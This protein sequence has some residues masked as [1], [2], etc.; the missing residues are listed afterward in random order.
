MGTL[1]ESQDPP[2]LLI[3]VLQKAKAN[4]PFLGL[5]PLQGSPLPQDNV[6]TPSSLWTEASRSHLSAAHFE[7]IPFKNPLPP[8][9]LSLDF[10]PLAFI[11]EKQPSF[12]Q[13]PAQ[14]SPVTPLLAKGRI[15]SLSVL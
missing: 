13:P 3:P 8:H 1:A 7:P 10:L 5:K 4:I 15:S 14:T 12:Q 11:S 9:L 6:G 2:V